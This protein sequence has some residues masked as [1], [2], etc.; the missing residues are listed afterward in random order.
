MI[1][2]TR[3]QSR[4]GRDKSAQDPASDTLMYCSRKPEQYYCQSDVNKLSIEIE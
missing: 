3:S 1:I 2:V 4:N